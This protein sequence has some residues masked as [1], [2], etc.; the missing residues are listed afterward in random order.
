MQ[1]GLKIKEIL[2][3]PGSMEDKIKEI[4]VF[5]NWDEKKLR[6]AILKYGTND[7]KQQGLIIKEF[8]GKSFS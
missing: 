4:R 5:M 3:G 7:N 1:V 6:E 2:S 8:W